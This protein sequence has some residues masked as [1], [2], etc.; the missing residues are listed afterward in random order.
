MTPEEV[1]QLIPEQDLV[2][3]AIHQEGIRRYLIFSDG[4]VV[5]L[6]EETIFAIFTERQKSA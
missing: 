5:Q 1:Q 3:M 6:S 2:T 4:E